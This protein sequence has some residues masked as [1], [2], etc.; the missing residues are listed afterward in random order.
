MTKIAAQSMVM[1]MRNLSVKVSEIMSLDR[2]LQC[3]LHLADSQIVL[4]SL[5]T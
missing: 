4:R 2:L 3:L 1:E 5:G